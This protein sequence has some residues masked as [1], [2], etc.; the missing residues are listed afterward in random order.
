MVD[1]INALGPCAGGTAIYKAAK[2]AMNVRYPKRSR[3]R[4]SPQTISRFQHL[5]PNL[6]LSNV[7]FVTSITH[8]GNW[9]QSEED[10][11]AI[12]IGYTMWFTRTRRE[13]EETADG[14]RLL[15]HELVHVEQVRRM[16]GSEEVFG[17]AYGTGYVQGGL[18]YDNNPLEIEAYDFED[19][20]PVPSPTVLPAIPLGSW[21]PAVRH[22]T[23]STT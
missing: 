16:G 15:M 23:M 19:V 4:L 14:L 22:M 11:D 17:C 21:F 18:K 8:P 9:F 20:H 1:V 10:F 2:L 12:T 13:V 7:R 5:F 6:T 3:R